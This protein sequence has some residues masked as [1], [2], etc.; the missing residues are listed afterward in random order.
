MS[1]RGI[2]KSI[3]PES[4]WPYLQI[5]YRKC[6]AIRRAITRSFTKREIIA[7]AEKLKPY[8]QDK[9]SLEILNDRIESINKPDDSIF[10]RRAQKEGWTFPELYSVDIRKYSGLS[11]IYDREGGAL[12]Y[13]RGTLAL[14]NFAE[15]WGG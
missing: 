13:A 9:L 6:W 11:V 8:Y 2:V 7:R 4:L 5:P 14:S 3:F 15:W 12:D 10:V 1:V